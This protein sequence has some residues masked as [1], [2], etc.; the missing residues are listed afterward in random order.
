MGGWRA[1]L[2]QFSPD[3]LWVD[4]WGDV[5]EGDGFD[6]DVRSTLATLRKLAGAANPDCGTVVLAHARTGAMNVAQAVGFEAAN[7]GKDS[8]ALFSC[9]RAV[10]N[11]APFDGGE[12]PDIVW[13]PAKNNNGLRPKPLRIR[14]DPLTL[15]YSL[16]E[17][18]DVEAWL[19]DVK[20][21]AKLSKRRVTSK[22]DDAA[23]LELAAKPR[24]K[25]ELHAAVR[26]MCV[27]ERDARAGLDRLLNSGQLVEH[28][29]G[30]RNA[31]LVGT[32]ESFLN[33]TN[34]TLIL[35]G[36]SK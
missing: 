28:K 7:F 6:R 20:A 30:N 23:V 13:A 33:T 36:L 2:A 19:E 5:L 35:S 9:A 32:P 4:P 10:V 18:L 3:V 16:V 1:T 27:T 31:K 25:T 8:K 24:S 11:I 17:P 22:F 29:A 21:A 15:T 14:L 12:M 34:P 26:D